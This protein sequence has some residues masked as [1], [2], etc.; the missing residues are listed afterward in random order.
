[1][2]TTQLY[3]GGTLVKRDFPVADISDYL[4]ANAGTVWADFVD[5]TAADLAVIE[6]ELSLHH[7]A[8]ED[9]IHDFQRPK[10]DQYDSHLFLAAYAVALDETSGELQTYEVKSFI[11]KHA[12]ITVHGKHFDMT[13][14]ASRWDND[15]ALSKHGSAFLLW[16]L[17]D[18]IVD[19][20]FEAVQS[21]D[22]QIEL[23]ED[24]LFDDRPRDREVQRRSFE[25]RKS[26][27][28]LRRVVTPMREVVN[29][30][31]RRESV[32][33]DPAMQPYFQDIYDHVMRATE[34]TESLRDLITTILE[35]NIAIQGNR[36]NLIMKKVTSWAAIIAVPTAITGFFG[37]N[38]LFPGYGTWWGVLVSSALIVIVGAAL[39]LSFTKR[40]WL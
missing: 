10:I 31:M 34:W 15:P 18:A 30:V 22:A 4:A 6:E 21:L 3:Q 20:H 29:T 11:T 19:S 32:A 36:M 17:L 26:L 28:L 16:G 35:T 37:Q 12:L 25:L 1:M 38:L 14:V 27:V 2:A 33:M 5:P 7:L 24:A 39:Y 9:A 13:S 8:I 40:D 23:L